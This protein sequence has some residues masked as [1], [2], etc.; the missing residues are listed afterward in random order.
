MS[1]RS[2]K[3]DKRRAKK[4]KRMPDETPARPP[5][6]AAR[7]SDNGVRISINARLLKFRPQNEAVEP[8]SHISCQ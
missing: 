7:G 6:S 5:H 4:V 1:G 8:P 3:G 2:C